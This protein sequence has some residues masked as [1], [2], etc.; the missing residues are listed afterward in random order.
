MEVRISS[1]PI[2]L[3][4]L[5]GMANAISVYTLDEQFSQTNQTVL[6]FRVENNTSDTLNGLELRYQVVQD[7]AMIA[8]PGI[9][10]LPEGMANWSFESATNATLVIYFPNVVLYPGETLGGTSGYALGL[11]NKDWSTWTKSDDPSQPA[12]NTFTLAD[13]VDV[14][15]GGVSL[16]HDVGETV[17]CP[18]V[19]FVEV[20]KDSVA[21]QILQQQ[22]SDTSSIVL[23]NKDGSEIVA[24]LNHAS[25]DAFGQRVWRGSMMT[26]DTA[27]HR[28]ELRAECGG[29]TIAYFA[30]GWEPTGA[31]DAVAKSLWAST[32]AFVQADFDMGFNQGL[33]DGQRLILQRDSSGNYLDAR[34]VANWK[35][36]RS[37]EEP[38][39]NSMPVILSSPI[40]QY[41][42]A[43]VDSLSFAWSSI[44]GVNL[45]HLM[46]VEVSKVGDSLVYGDTVFSSA[47]ELSS[48]TIATLPAGN[49]VW[50]VE[51]LVEVAMDENEDGAEYCYVNGNVVSNE[52]RR[53]LWKKFKK[54]AKKTV[55]KATQV[56]APVLYTAFYGGNLMD[57]VS[58][59][60]SHFNAIGIIQV[61]VPTTT[62]Y[63]K[64]NSITKNMS[65]LSKSYKVE[66]VYS[67]QPNTY[68]SN[69]CFS[70]NTFCAMKDTRMLAETWGNGYDENNWQKLF[71]RDDVDGYTNMAVHN[72]CWLTMAQMINHYKGGNISSDE[73]L[74]YVRGGFRDTTGGGPVESMQAVNYA[75]GMTAWDNITYTALLNAYRGSGAI[76][77]VD[78]WSVGTPTLHTIMNVIEAG[79]VLGVSQLNAGN[80]GSHSMVLNGYKIDSN[81]D[82]Y[83]HLLNTDNMG[84][85]E[86]RYYCTISSLGTDVI[87]TTILNGIGHLIDLIGNLVNKIPKVNIP[88]VSGNTFFT[89]YVPPLYASGRS[90]NASVF[91]DN[92]NDGVVDFDEI[93]RFGTDA[94]NPDSDGDGLSDS[95]E[96]LEFKRCEVYSGYFVS[97]NTSFLAN[98]SQL[99]YI[100]QSD[101]DGDGLHAAKDKDSDG[102]GFCDAQEMA[103]LGNGY[104]HNCERFDASRH[105]DGVLPL[106]NGNDYNLALLAKE[107]LQ[108]NDRASCITMSGSFC[109]VASYGF[110]Y[111]EPYGVSLGVNSFVGN[112]Y[113]TKSVLLRDRSKV[114]GNLETAGSVVKQ[115]S[116]AV[117]TGAVVENST[118][119]TAYINQYA[120][121]LNNAVI[122]GNFTIYRQHMVNSG[123]IAYSHIMG[124]GANNTE[125]I[126]NSGSGIVF[127]SVGDLL[128]GSLKFQQGS[129]LYAPSESVVFHIGNEFQ[130]NGTIVTDNMVSAAQRIQVYYYGTDR[131]FIQ[132]DF[133]G[134][135][136]APN[137]EVVVGQAGKNFYG[138]IYAKSI[139]IHQN[140][141]ITWVPFVQM[142]GNVVAKVDF[143]DLNYVVDFL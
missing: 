134:T 24:N 20:S 133:A 35:F 96:L 6:R 17:G 72:R 45:Y 119:S 116:T 92:D 56:F 99:S 40:M 95:L 31:E 1:F 3:L 77:S 53:G 106:C 81:G 34:Q 5:A 43:D 115:S 85:A 36:Y 23:K 52:M 125:F 4:A 121:I 11:H 26:Q 61:F 10:Y 114:Y 89:F 142:Q 135:I 44:E 62:L 2:F 41:S 90:A 14:L 108:L 141:K 83:I 109:S 104:A 33:I 13:N 117:V 107:K 32:N 88:S 30:F 54:W 130:W 140:T 19:Q 21:L 111:T 27:E 102:D 128:A 67:A 9:Y 105:P 70:S 138:A 38:G 58:Y 42:A 48:L 93:E 124:A 60:I 15:S 78:G 76:P 84:T 12:S 100:L 63:T 57:N 122:N 98:I 73:I 139:V 49:Y 65:E 74:Y 110:N 112:I 28:G 46:V 18:M 94:L 66:Y 47:T 25:I 131:V 127:N 22:D 118:N 7:T 71:L 51:P 29:N 137:A 82:V 101:F 103:Y 64:T 129:M 97:L 87:V 86:W 126:F 132:S 69:Q 39:E 113:S 75:L 79:N 37:W 16:M 50:F 80:K 59:S 55:K 91:A 120:P 8:D 68:F 123:E 143:P 136:I